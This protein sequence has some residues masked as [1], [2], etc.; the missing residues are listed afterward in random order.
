MAATD[1]E[2]HVWNKLK[3]ID[4]KTLEKLWAKSI[5]DLLGTEYRCDISSLSYGTLE[6]ARVELTISLKLKYDKFS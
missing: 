4:T 5:S 1:A 2:E 6:Q 3:T